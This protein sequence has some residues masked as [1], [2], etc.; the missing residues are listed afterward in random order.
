M[1]SAQGAQALFF[2]VNGIV[3]A[4]SGN[5]RSLLQNLLIAISLSSVFPP[6]DD[7]DI[8]LSEIYNSKYKESPPGGH[9]FW[10]EQNL[11]KSIN[12]AHDPEDSSRP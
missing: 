1:R 2:S 6:Q 12:P 4:L 3:L 7:L 9:G 10:D 5:K 8:I 11:S